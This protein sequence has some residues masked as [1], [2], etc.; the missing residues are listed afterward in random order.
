MSIAV[1][2]GSGSSQQ[3]NEAEELHGPWADLWIDPLICRVRVANHRPCYRC[4]MLVPTGSAV[5]RY[6]D[7]LCNPCS[8][9]AIQTATTDESQQTAQ[10]QRPA[11][12]LARPGQEQCEP[13]VKRLEPTAACL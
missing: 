6:D 7:E 10:D 4:H 8:N 9:T 2:A 1:L 12:A 3:Q 13:A 11:M 5:L